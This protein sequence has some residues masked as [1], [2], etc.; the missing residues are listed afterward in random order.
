[1]QRKMIMNFTVYLKNNRL[2]K[3]FFKV[4]MYHKINVSMKIEGIC[5]HE[6]IVYI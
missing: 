4:E 6:N 2:I 1:M 3:F 5:A